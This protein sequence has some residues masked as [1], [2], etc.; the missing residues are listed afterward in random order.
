M[1][2][3]NININN[4]EIYFIDYIDGKLTPNEQEELLLF[5]NQNPILAKELIN[6]SELKLIPENIIYSGK[7]NLKRELLDKGDGMSKAEMLIISDLEGDLSE[8]E[9]QELKLLK[10]NDNDVATT[11]EIIIK[12]KLTP[13]PK[14][15]F[16]EKSRLKRTALLGINY[17]TLNTFSRIAASII[18]LI[19][20]TAVLNTLVFNPKSEALVINNNNI[21]N[22]IKEPREIELPFNG[23]AKDSSIRH[24]ESIAGKYI[25]PTNDS[26][27]VV[28]EESIRTE[29]EL[30]YISRREPKFATNTISVVTL[31]KSTLLGVDQ[32]LNSI[33]P[34]NQH[35][36]ENLSTQ[37]TKEFGLFELAQLG[38]KKIS[39]MTG[40]SAKL[41][42]ERDEKGKLIRVNFETS[43]FA[44]S[45]PIAKK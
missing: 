21:N 35:N 23:V 12:T 39:D 25:K 3:N 20:L 41:E 22:D 5:L 38:V 18:V 4:Y 11:A 42:G 31:N 17:H 43:L 33:T 14:E 30:S 6:I 32:F 16:G 7:R 9:A 24:T 15:V 45:T 40:S 34:P 27:V 1:M 8:N 37:S 29:V 13:N 28:K 2:N 19:G 26:K 36:S 44:I 10:S